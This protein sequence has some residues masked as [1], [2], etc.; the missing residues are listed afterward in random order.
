M[1]VSRCMAELRLNVLLLNCCMRGMLLTLDL[2]L[3]YAWAVTCA[4]SV[5]K[6][7]SDQLRSIDS[8]LCHAVAANYS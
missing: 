4:A 6:L 7:Y 3:P 2:C 1:G 8:T 5:E